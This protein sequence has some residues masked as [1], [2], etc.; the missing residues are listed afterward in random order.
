M[1]CTLIRLRSKQELIQAK[2]VLRGGAWPE[3]PAG[4]IIPVGLRGHGVGQERTR[5]GTR[6][7]RPTRATV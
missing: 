7:E 5:V 6:V 2:V 3:I 1:V 4:V